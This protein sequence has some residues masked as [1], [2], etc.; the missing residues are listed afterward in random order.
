M[1]YW[2][3]SD[4]EHGNEV[5]Q[6]PIAPSKNYLGCQLNQV[7]DYCGPL[8]LQNSDSDERQELGSTELSQYMLLPRTKQGKYAMALTHV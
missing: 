2:E 5:R 4:V 8:N 6:V 7:T 1:G 3:N